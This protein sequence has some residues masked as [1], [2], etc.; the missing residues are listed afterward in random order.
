MSEPTSA[1]SATSAPTPAPTDSTE[2]TTDSTE[3]TDGPT[4]WVAGYPWGEMPAIPPIL[5]PDL[6]LLDDSVNGFSVQVK[7]VTGNYPGLTIG[8]ARCDEAGSVQTQNGS[9]L[10]YGDGSGI[11]TGPDGTSINYGDGSGTY[12]INGVTVQVFGDGSGL[13]DDGTTSIQNYGDGSG[14]YADDETGVDVQIYGDGSGTYNDLTMSNQNYGDG[15]GMYT[16]S[17]TGVTIQNYGDGSG[18]YSDETITIQNFGDGTGM[19]DG[20]PVDLEPI[21]VL[22]VLGS[23]P[24]MGVLSPITSCG[25]TI[26]LDSGVLFDIDQYAIRPDSAEVLDSLAQALT[27]L[28]VPAAEIAGHTDDVRDEAWNQTLSENRAAAVVRALEQRGVAASLTAVGYGETR[29]IAP[30]IVN[31]VPDSAGRQLNR[32]VEIFIPAF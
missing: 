30:N 32:R 21:P 2:P 9:L 4:A 7:E 18:M 26:S 29:P 25:T 22:A 31:G 3:T 6:A 12:T 13:Y 27:E 1:A 19:V 23:F 5:L 11:H 15:S 8:P 10:L 28:E 17:E 24:P 14:V 20:E 16:N